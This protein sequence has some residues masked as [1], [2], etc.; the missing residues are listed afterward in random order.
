M[1]NRVLF[2]LKPFFSLLHTTLWLVQWCLILNGT[3]WSVRERL[4]AEVKQMLAFIQYLSSFIMGN[5]GY[6]EQSQTEREVCWQALYA[7]WCVGLRLQRAWEN[8]FH[9]SFLPLLLTTSS[10][11]TEKGFLL[12]SQVSC[13]YR[14]T[15]KSKTLKHSDFQFRCKFRTIQQ[16]KIKTW[17][18][19]ILFRNCK[20]P[21]SNSFHISVHSQNSLHLI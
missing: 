5:R 19:E 8:V 3:E 21:F 18:F 7:W 13:I 17:I 16:G 11:I 2:H 10:H 14:S 20:A 9:S 1:S 4:L 12:V 15:I 6:W